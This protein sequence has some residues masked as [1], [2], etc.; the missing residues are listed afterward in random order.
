MPTTAQVQRARA[1]EV[2]G[3]V[4]YVLPSSSGSNAGST[5]RAGADCDSAITGASAIGKTERFDGAFAIYRFNG[6]GN[7]KR[8]ASL[9][10]LGAGNDSLLTTIEP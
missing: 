10:R 8:G 2:T 3:A 9:I 7:P 6:T 1:S 5:T 4:W